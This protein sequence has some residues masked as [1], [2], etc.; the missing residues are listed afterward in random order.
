[1]LSSCRVRIPDS[2]HPWLSVSSVSLLN[3]PCDAVAYVTG[4]RVI[5][6]CFL[7]RFDLS[8][9]YTFATPSSLMI[10]LYHYDHRFSHASRRKTVH[11]SNVFL[12]IFRISFV[13]LL[14]EN[15]RICELTVVIVQYSL[16]LVNRHPEPY[17]D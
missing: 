7:L 16:S 10:L 15:P 14:V 1:M 2:T 4:P 6:F 8:S 12:S 17:R 13:F 5:R 11:R 3:E 9:I